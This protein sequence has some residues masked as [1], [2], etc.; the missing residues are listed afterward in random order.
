MSVHFWDEQPYGSW[1]VEI[2]NAGP[3]RARGIVHKLKLKLYGTYNKRKHRELLGGYDSIAQKI[4]AQRNEEIDEK[5][6]ISTE[7]FE[8]N[9]NNDGN[10][11]LNQNSSAEDKKKQLMIKLIFSSLFILAWIK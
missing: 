3:T 4:Q 6:T 2:K 10:G 1:S 9:S 8:W 7:S 11:L 5:S